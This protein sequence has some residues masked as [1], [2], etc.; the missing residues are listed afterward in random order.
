MGNHYHLMIRV[1]AN[2]LNMSVDECGTN[3]K[4]T[5]RRCSHEKGAHEDGA[6]NSEA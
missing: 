4:H 3:S 1:M 6:K 5:D 2:M